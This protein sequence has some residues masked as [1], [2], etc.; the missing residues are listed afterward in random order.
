MI[1]R[2]RKGSKETKKPKKHNVIVVNGPGTKRWA[3]REIRELIE[4]WKALFS[5]VN[6]LILSL[7]MH[8]HTVLQNLS[9]E[10][11][12]P[13]KDGQIQYSRSLSHTLFWQPK[14]AG[15]LI[16]EEEQLSWLTEAL[17]LVFFLTKT[18][19]SWCSDQ[20]KGGYL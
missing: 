6:S 2:K 16:T 8:S 7:N 13:N 14:L 1:E 5:A 10:A 4:I 18:L 20:W 15:K 19:I 11:N 12:I 9:T 17:Q 3:G